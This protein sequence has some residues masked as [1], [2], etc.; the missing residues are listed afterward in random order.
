MD[1][2]PAVL[3]AEDDGELRA[4]LARS[5]EQAGY[6]VVEC[7]DG[8]ELLR[9]LAQFASSRMPQWQLVISDV[10][11]PGVSTMDMLGA[12]HRLEEWQRI[13]LMTGFPNDVLVWL[14]RGLGVAEVLIK[15]FSTET[16]VGKVRALIP[17]TRG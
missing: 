3:L 5:L 10:R 7:R 16:L 9:R 14:A 12:L 1:A 13:I 15:P 6:Q 4:L 17:A 2:Q 8:P 11:M